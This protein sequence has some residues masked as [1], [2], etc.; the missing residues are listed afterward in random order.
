MN[1]ELWMLTTRRDDI[2]DLIKL[3][4]GDNS[5][6]VHVLGRRGP[7]ILPVHDLLDA[8]ITVESSF[9][10]GRLKTCFYI[11]DLE[12]WSLALDALGAG[13]DA[14]WL[15]TGN[16]PVIRIEL[17][18]DDCDIPAVHIEDASGSGT[19]ATIPIVLDYG[20]IEEQREHLHEAMRA[21]P[22]EVLKT[23]PGA[24]EWR[25]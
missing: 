8:E 13:Q 6:R 25:H 10:S 14:E 24:Y 2:V 16:G 23:S 5:V 21:W 12:E 4:D 19:S 18:D 1:A 17:P 7:G 3:S 22:S 9:V 20:W 11:S 15:D